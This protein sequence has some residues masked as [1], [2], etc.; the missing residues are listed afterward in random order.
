MT[1]LHPRSAAELL[2][3]DAHRVV[4]QPDDFVNSARRPVPSYAAACGG[5]ASDP[6][7]PFGRFAFTLPFNMSE[8]P[9]AA[10]CERLCSAQRAWPLPPAS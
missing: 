1:D 4:C 9:S 10:A 8:Q 3:P 7:R 5:P 2:A 6:Q